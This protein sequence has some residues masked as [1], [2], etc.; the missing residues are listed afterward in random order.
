CPSYLVDA[1]AELPGSLAIY[2]YVDRRIIERLAELKV[3]KRRDF[4]H[5]S[6]DS[7]PEAPIGAEVGP[8]DGDLYRSWSPKIH[9]L[10]YDVACF[11]RCRCSRN[12]VWELP[13]Q[14]FLQVVDAHTR[15]RPQGDQ[16]NG[17]LGTTG[18]EIYR[19]DRIARRLRSHKTERDLNVIRSSFS[20][21][22]I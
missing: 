2:I 20:F 8:I 1:H 15:I 9:D 6:E 18:P 16:Q 21:D 12:N 17:F 14:P 19:I 13:A 5:L 11:K 7:F 4:L 10:A 22:C 3:T